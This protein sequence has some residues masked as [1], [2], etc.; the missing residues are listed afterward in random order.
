MGRKDWK[1][2]QQAELDRLLNL[3]EQA[4]TRYAAAIEMMVDRHMVNSDISPNAKARIVDFIR[5]H[6]QEVFDVL[7]QFYTGSP[8]AVPSQAH[9][10]G[11]PPGFNLDTPPHVQPGLLRTYPCVPGGI[12]APSCTEGD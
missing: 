6:G 10:Q 1:Y 3:K 4:D 7:G 11:N 2:E 9:M 12:A 8:V 5:E